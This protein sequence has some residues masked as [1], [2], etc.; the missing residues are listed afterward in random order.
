MKIVITGHNSLL[1]SNLAKE[2]A[3][4]NKVILLGTRNKIYKKYKFKYDLQILEINNLEEFFKK[5]KEI[6]LF[7]HCAGMN[8]NSCK[9]KEKEAFEFNVSFTEKLTKLCV[10]NKVRSFIYLSSVNVYQKS[11]NQKIFEDSPLSNENIYSIYKYKAEE[12]IEKIA[13]YSSMKFQILRLSNVLAKPLNIDTNCWDLV[14]YNLCKEITL[15][16]TITIKTNALNKRDFFDIKYLI[17]FINFFITNSSKFNSGTKNFCSGQNISILDL[18]LSLQSLTLKNFFFKPEIIEIN[19]RIDLDINNASYSVDE[20]EKLGFRVNN[21]IEDIL[22]DILLTSKNYF[23][24][25]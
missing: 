10:L 5:E 20:I 12:I 23:S 1:G 17:D 9:N 14:V 2:L 4:S 19:K 8:S 15:N 24:K 21:D 11:L 22:E 6:D 13:K 16:R 7:I 3:V 25:I 18:S